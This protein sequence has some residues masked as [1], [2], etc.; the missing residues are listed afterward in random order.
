MQETRFR[1][2]L[3]EGDAMEWF[4][5]G[6]LERRTGWQKGKRNGKVE[7]WYEDGKKKGVT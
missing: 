4:P 2:G 7:T 1:D 6:N 5:N 3:A